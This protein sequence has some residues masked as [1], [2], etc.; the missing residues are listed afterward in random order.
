[1]IG[2][3][4]LLLCTGRLEEAACI[5]RMF[6]RH[7]RDGLIPN[8][9]PE[10]RQ[11]PVYHT[12]DATLWY[13]H[14]LERYLRHGGDW[15]TVS[16]LLPLLEGEARAADSGRAATAQVAAEPMTLARALEELF[17]DDTPWVRA[18]VC[19]YAAEKRVATA[20]PQ[21]DALTGDPDPVVR[22]SA[23][24]AMFRAH[25]AQSVALAASRLAD[26]SPLV[27]KRAALVTTRAQTSVSQSA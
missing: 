26:E 1:M 14:A 16:G 8:F 24:E 15:E 7:A 9:F 10:G 2:L 22:E 13:F 21:L 25:P 12:A 19:L 5:L 3:E 20:L 18:C 6:A 4:G 11:E 17:N 23:L 27:R